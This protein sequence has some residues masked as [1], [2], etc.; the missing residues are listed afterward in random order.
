MKLPNDPHPA[1]EFAALVVHLR[2][3]YGLT[4]PQVATLIEATPN[5]KTRKQ[6]EQRLTTWAKT[7]AKG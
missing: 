7:L 6:T 3:K 1:N 2:N 5:G 4:V